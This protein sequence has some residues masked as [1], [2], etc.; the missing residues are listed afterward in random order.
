M[1]A[2]LLAVFFLFAVSDISS[3]REVKGVDFPESATVG[4]KTCTLI[5]VGVRKKIIINVYL[6]ALYMEKPT[7]A[8][9]EVISSD[10]AKRILMHFLYREVNGDQLVEAWN[11]GFEKNAPDAIPKLKDR[12]ARFNG[13]FTGSVKKGDSV[14]ISYIPGTGTEVEI[15]GEKKGVIEGRDFMEALFSI[16]FGPHPPSGGLKEGMMGED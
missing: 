7:T 5:G 16:W 11:E 12:I 6:G 1:F 4:G 8:Y 15:R 9:S 3:A 14:V 13:F 10:Q 2:L